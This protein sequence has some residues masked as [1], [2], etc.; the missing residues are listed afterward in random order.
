MMGIMTHDVLNLCLRVGGSG[1]M[2]MPQVEGST[3]ECIE[4][5]T[6]LKKISVSFSL[7]LK[8]EIATCYWRI[9]QSTQTQYEHE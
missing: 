1:R 4:A 7:V 3:D 2:A 8:A 9:S 5:D 6:L